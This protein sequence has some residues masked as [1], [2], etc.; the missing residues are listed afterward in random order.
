MT[1]IKHILFSLW[2]ERILLRLWKPFTELKKNF[3]FLSPRFN[4][5]SRDFFLR[6]LSSASS[7]LTYSFSSVLWISKSEGFVCIRH[8][9][10]NIFSEILQKYLRLN[11]FKTPLTFF[12]L[13]HKT[14]MGVSMTSLH[15]VS[16][17]KGRKRGWSAQKSKN[18][19]GSFLFSK[20]AIL[21]NIGEWSKIPKVESKFP[22][23]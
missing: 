21:T 23:L 10:S 20:L 12:N 7:S 4:H 16:K 9:A 13:L 18:L 19:N 5:C 22:N 3:E 1:S 2:I 6:K 17:I 15:Y 14:Y 11:Y 8:W